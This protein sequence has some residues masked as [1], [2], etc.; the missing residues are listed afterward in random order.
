LEFETAENSKAVFQMPDTLL[1]YQIKGDNT[2][3][4]ERKC[5]S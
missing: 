1:H 5:E 2:M 4:E 3:E